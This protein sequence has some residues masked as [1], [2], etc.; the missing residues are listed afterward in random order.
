MKTVV[1]TGSSKGLGKELSMFF[2]KNNWKVIGLSRTS[3]DFS[4]ENY[5]QY[6]CD[7]KDS[8]EVKNIV[9]TIG[10][11]DL[12]I[13]N[14]AS[15]EML[16]FS[17]SSVE[18]IDTIIDTNLKGAMYVTHSCLPYINQ[19]GKIIF[20]NSV[21]GLRD[22]EN[23]SIYCASKA[24]L[25]SFASVLAQELK[26]KKIKV[27]TIHPGGIN[28]TLWNDNNPYPCGEASN[29]L[30]PESIVNLVYMIASDTSNAEYKSITLFPEIEW[31]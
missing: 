21:A 31:H 4:L 30:N 15:F 6:K 14:A 20:I 22:I 11:I 2:S 19:G 9:D 13:N 26:S 16:E 8:K 1:I 18:S 27:S 23:Q 12:L 5:K 17:K 3:N 24:G 10:N 29:A 25:K 28:T 7:I